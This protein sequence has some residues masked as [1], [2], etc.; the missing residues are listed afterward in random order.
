MK[1]FWVLMLTLL[2]LQQGCSLVPRLDKSQQNHKV[3]KTQDATKEHKIDKK[4][5]KFG[6][7]SHSRKQRIT[8]V[9]FKFFNKD[10]H[11]R[12]K[13]YKKKMKEVATGTV[14]THFDP[15]GIQF[16]T[17]PRKGV[18]LDEFLFEHELEIAVLETQSY[19][20]KEVDLA[21]ER[22]ADTL[23]SDEKQEKTEVEKTREL[24][25]VTSIVDLHPDVI[26]LQH[27]PIKTMFPRGL[28]KEP[29][30]ANIPVF[31]NDAV[32]TF[33]F[34]KK[35]DYTQKL[36]NQATIDF[37]NPAGISS[38]EIHYTLRGFS[39]KNGENTTIQTQNHI[40][41]MTEEYSKEFNNNVP[42]V[43]VVYRNFQGDLYR[44]IMPNIAF[45]ALRRPKNIDGKSDET[46]KGSSH[47]SYQ[48]WNDY[49]KDFS[50]LAIQE[51]D[52]IEFTTLDLLDLTS[53]VH[54]EVMSR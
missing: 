33:D 22:D 19:I 26:I 24:E 23:P 41:P 4:E 32:I 47:I 17:V 27:G 5:S 44:I 52:V 3:A 45:G 43:T 35:T 49:F 8:L 53:P 48:K 29:Q 7:E 42:A 54:A 50:N 21:R 30:V 10:Q 31:P 28:L 16:F 9:D 40:G 38:E 13:H 39:K 18:R 14:V 25:K 11:K 15:V 20:N 12:E 6:G 1:Q 36:L 51:G 34:N 2:L 46:K 37:S